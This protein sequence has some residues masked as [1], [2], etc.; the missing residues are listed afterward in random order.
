M[1]EDPDLLRVRIS[2][3]EGGA[4]EEAWLQVAPSI[5]E[6]ALKD[7]EGGLP[8]CGMFLF[9]SADWCVEESRPLPE[10]VRAEFRNRL[11]Y[12]VQ[13]IGGSTPRLFASVP[14]EGEPDRR[15]YVE[16]GVVAITF[17]S[18]DMWFAVRSLEIPF[19]LSESER[20][21]RLSELGEELYTAR[22]QHM[23]LGSS[24]QLD[25]L[26][27][28]PGPITAQDGRREF[29]DEELFVEILD[30]FKGLLQVF[31][32]S[33]GDSVPSSCG[34]QFAN[35]HCLVSGLAVAL[36]ENDLQPSVAMGHGFFL[37]DDKLWMPVTAVASDNAEPSYYVTELGGQPAAD[38]LNGWAERG[39]FER[40]RPLF[41][42]GTNPHCQI[43]ATSAATP[44]ERGPVRFNRRLPL[45]TPLFVL[46]GDDLAL[47]RG[48]LQVINQAR[49]RINVPDR[50]MRLFFAV[51]CA[52]RFQY[53]GD[54]REELWHDCM[55][56]MAG[57]TCGTPLVCILCSG[58]FAEDHRGRPRADSY[59][60]WVS[61]LSSSKGRR[62]ETRMLQD[63]LLQASSA[64]LKCDT[65]DE[66][67]DAALAGAIIAGAEGGQICLA[68]KFTNAILGLQVGHAKNRLGG[69]QR[70]ELVI[71][72]TKVRLPQRTQRLR[73]PESL[74]SGLTR[75]TE[76]PEGV[77]LRDLADDD[78]VL[79]IVATERGSLF[80]PDS[81]KPEYHCHKHRVELGRVE[82]QFVAPLIGSGDELIGTF[83]VGFQK[84]HPMDRERMGL[85]TGFSQKTAAALERAL[86]REERRRLEK[87]TE[88]WNAIL[89]SATP[90]GDPEP[91]LLRLTTAILQQMEAT[92]VHL[93][94]RE[95]FQGSIRHKLAASVGSLAGLHGKVRPYINE[96]EG[97]VGVATRRGTTFTHRQEDTTR[98]YLDAS[99]VAEG[100]DS[101]TRGRWIE[102]SGLLKSTGILEL[103]YRQ[104]L[105]GILVVDS[106]DEFF[107]TE[108]RKRIAELAAQKVAVILAKLRIEKMQQQV[109]QAG[110]YAA[111]NIHD[112]MRPLCRIQRSVDILREIGLGDDSSNEVKSLE[113]AKNQAVQLLINAAQGIELGEA[114]TPLGELLAFTECHG[115]HVA[116]EP[117]RLKG[118]AVKTTVWLRSAVESLTEN[119][120]EA[121]EPSGE[122]RISVRDLSDDRVCIQIENSGPVLTPADIQNMFVTGHSTKGPD[123]LGLGI[124]LADFGVRLAGGEFAL[125]PR[126]GGGLRAIV[127]LPLASDIARAAV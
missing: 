117:P 91:L 27:F 118:R 63:R 113:S 79:E 42:I 32:G 94:L 111:K 53:G 36:L 12:E 51:C 101:E 18:R 52:G 3:F 37:R 96:D 9:A 19:S 81:A 100:V 24:V 34:Y 17:F 31:G 119:A 116:W 92:Y 16:R 82:A 114:L 28:M 4:S 14:K 87:I 110:L 120:R 57:E 71:P 15:Y 84:G 86:E 25:L 106:G 20:R 109:V 44:F 74:R 90:V 26:A 21:R 2:V 105:L 124:P 40:G 41:G 102:E 99:R 88:V 112:I 75:S 89:Q 8:V 78:D 10:R 46:R 50:L 73:I 6:Q 122:I 93:R 66:V 59:S 80:I 98:L 11:G 83:Q 62:S 35:D 43:A 55:S 104:D 72:E 58:E 23:G 95:L 76:V 61:C 69:T 49:S 30:T 127:Y 29:K 70:W 115:I 125:E 45:G 97:T 60:L 65:P 68:D 108:R 67:M 85:W 56:E 121:V 103:R 22:G 48:A 5:A 126:T 7:R 13:L 123:H 54:L 39:L 38:V 64:L 107:F 1:A 33:M 77:D 47:R